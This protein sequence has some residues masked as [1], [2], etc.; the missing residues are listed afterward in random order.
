[1]GGYPKDGIGQ[2]LEDPHSA[3]VSAASETRAQGGEA[4]RCS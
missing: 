3:S 1:M 4:S 2:D